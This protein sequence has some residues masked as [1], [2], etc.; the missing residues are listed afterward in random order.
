MAEKIILYS[1]P[2]CAYS[3]ALKEQLDLLGEEYE[4]VDLAVHPEEWATV[5]RLAGGERIT[6]VL[7]EGDLVTVGYHGV[8]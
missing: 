6:P 3:A 7:V 1:S 8:G 4:E 5:E 2:D